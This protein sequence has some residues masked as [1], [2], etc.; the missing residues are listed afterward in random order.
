MK[1]SFFIILTL[2]LFG[3]QHISTTMQP[4]AKNKEDR[5]EEL[6]RFGSEFA[7]QFNRDP[8]QTCAKYIQLHQD[9]EW[10]AS[11]VLALTAN[12]TKSE[13]CLNSEDAIQILTTLESQGKMYSELKWLNQFHLQLLN[14]IQQKS[15][16]LSDT[17]DSSQKRRKNQR[18]SKKGLK[19]QIVELREENKDLNDKLDALKNI[20]KDIKPPIIRAE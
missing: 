9:G 6:L 13:H 17:V 12:K 8:K 2:T 5:L 7:K 15:S 1:R 18:L 16:Q 11:W 3:C 4:V 20:E 10:R 14:K 19:R